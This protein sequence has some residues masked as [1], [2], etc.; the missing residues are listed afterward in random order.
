MRANRGEYLRDARR[1]FCSAGPWTTSEVEQRIWFAWLACR[2]QH[3]NVYLNLPAFPGGAILEDFEHAALRL[4]RDALD[5]TRLQ[6]ERRLWRSCARGARD[7]EHRH[8]PNNDEAWKPESF[9]HHISPRVVSVGVILYYSAL[10]SP[11]IRVTINEASGTRASPAAL[12]DSR[13][14]R[15]GRNGPGLQS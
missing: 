8:Y 10:N 9:A 2:G 15:R 13:Q 1:I 12:P 5:L 7:L 11:E 3:E 14:D 4:A 6:L